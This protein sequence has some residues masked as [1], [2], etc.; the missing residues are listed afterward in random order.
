MAMTKTATIFPARKIITMD[1][2]RSAAE[3]VAV[4]DGNVVG[5]GTADELRA[6][7]PHRIDDTFRNKVLMPGLVEGHCHLMEGGIWNFVY[8]GF[9]DRRGPDG[10]LWTGLRSFD[11]VVARLKAAE[12]QL[13]DPQQPLLAWG[14]D[15]V[16]F[17]GG[18]MTTHELDQVSSTRRIAVLHASIH[19]MNVNSA[20]LA[21]AGLDR[22]IRAEGV[23]KAADGELTGELQEF[24]AM[25]PV[26]RVIG[27]AFFSAA[28]TEAGIRNFGCSANIAG[29][30]TAT[31]LLSDCND[32]AVANL[33]R[34]TGDP[35]FPLRIIPAF[36]GF[37]ADPQQ[38]I[39]TVTRLARDATERLRF[40]AVKLVLDGSIQ[41][42]TARLRAPG[43]HDGSPNGQWL[44]A[45]QQVA[46]SVGAYHRAGLQLHIHTNGDEATDVALEALE[47]A[48]ADR[49]RHDHRHTIQHAQMAD[50]AQLQRM[51]DLGI[52]VNLFANHIYYWG[53]VHYTRTV[54]PKRAHR[55]NAVGTAS[56]LGVHYA[57]H[58]DAPITPLGPLFTAWCAVNRRTMSGRV[59]GE[60][61]RIPVADALHAITL[62]AAY[63]LKLD[64]EIGSIE[65]GK[66]ADFAVLD[67]DP[68]EIAPEQLKDVGI[69][70]TV[71]GGRV[72]RSPLAR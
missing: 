5:V 13:A 55:M 40:G 31:D 63:T 50:A 38:G 25:F 8:V 30:T 20:M 39:D 12:S 33:F 7:G 34:V 59:L 48:L 18:R 26:F 65:S 43:Y 60:T 54:G 64:H 32:A 6:L 1:P 16:Y 42:F 72:F 22:S 47:R 15:P 53:D 49:P 11:A 29:V 44:M 58:S 4:R 24:A 52:C 37:D 51:A 69:W 36:R 56:R 68:L 41:G 19:L 57:I 35:A 62:G 14:F 2:R 70:G 28:E 27:N 3:A 46:E 17:V 9:Y 61:E 45:P 66:R 67:D 10:T 23:I 71:V 21:A